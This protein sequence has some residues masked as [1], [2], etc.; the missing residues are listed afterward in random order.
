[1]R[2][3]ARAESAA[4]LVL[5][6][7]VPNVWTSMGCRLE[8]PMSFAGN[9]PCADPPRSHG[10]LI[11][12]MFVSLVLPRALSMELETT[13]SYLG[14]AKEYKA[15]SCEMGNENSK[16]NRYVLEEVYITK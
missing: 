16:N 11:G 1:M 3:S 9:Y 6:V 5:V 10:I 7:P 12:R 13:N 14:L 2:K 4:G 15:S 8:D